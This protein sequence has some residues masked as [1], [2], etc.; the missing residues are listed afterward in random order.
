GTFWPNLIWVAVGFI[1]ADL[2]QH[3]VFSLGRRKYSPGVATSAL[4]LIFVVYFFLTE[5]GGVNE[6]V[7]PLL[8][9]A[10]GTAGLL[11]NYILA[12]RKV[13]KWRQSR[14]PVPA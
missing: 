1:T 8:P 2:I 14:E 3:G 6:N 5:L 7:N 12:S 4:Y 9:L 13:R 10:I 11:S